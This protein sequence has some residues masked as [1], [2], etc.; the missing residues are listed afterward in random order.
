[1]ISLYHS[2]YHTTGFEE[3]VDRIGRREIQAF[4]QQHYTPSR[5][6]LAVVGD[7]NPSTVRQFAEKYFGGWQ[8]AGGGLIGGGAGGGFGGSGGASRMLA[9][10]PFVG[11]G[12]TGWWCCGCGWLICAWSS[13]W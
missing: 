4:F 3:D 9:T 5:L 1:M 10:T 2:L 12:M 13:S 11:Q 6:T 7:V 8:P